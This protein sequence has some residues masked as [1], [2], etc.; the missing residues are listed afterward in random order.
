MPQLPATVAANSSIKG[1][2]L[3][4]N[5]PQPLQGFDVGVWVHD[6][7]RNKTVLLGQFTSILLTIRVGT[8]LY[9]GANQRQ[10]TLLDGEFYIAFDLEKGLI[11]SDVIQETLGFKVF[12]K[13]NVYL[14]SPRFTITFALDPVDWNAL[15]DNS[16]QF[17]QVI[18]RYPAG[19]IALTGC[20][21][22]TLMIAA[23]GGKSVAANK[24]RGLCEGL[25]TD[26]QTLARLETE[27][28]DAKLE[29]DANG[30]AYDITKVRTFAYS[31]YS[32]QASTYFP[33]WEPSRVAGGYNGLMTAI[34]YA[35][36][37]AER[38]RLMLISYIPGVLAAIE[39]VDNLIGTIFGSST[40]NP[41]ASFAIPV[42]PSELTQA[43][44]SEGVGDM[45]S[46]N[47]AGVLQSAITQAKASLNNPANAPNAGSIKQ[48]IVRLQGMLDTLQNGGVYP[49]S[50]S[51]G[52]P[53]MNANQLLQQQ[54]QMLLTEAQSATGEAKAN[55]EIM[56]QSFG[57]VLQNSILTSFVQNV[58]QPNSETT[59]SQV[60]PNSISKLD[61]TLSYKTGNIPTGSGITS[62]NQP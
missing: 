36:L 43:S 29:F 20:K 24:W 48:D 18:S 57:T 14:R 22:D 10:A 39:A 32:D 61:D 3:N 58:P 56:I 21:M 53:G 5:G 41:T 62:S 8:E 11:S 30:N 47:G 6:D 27:H 26:T 25:I 1:S 4:N 19:S 49:V 12:S 31:S 37:I 33:L 54:Y 13:D 23:T 15:G 52:T 17:G 59:K 45:S 7:G 40:V 51:V 34:T 42:D 9:L 16:L 55:L 35:E 2:V 46:A 44:Y 38:A 50:Y 28:P 60:L